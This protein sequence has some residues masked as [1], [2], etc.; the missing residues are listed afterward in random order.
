MNSNISIN[1]EKLT[2]IKC[3]V[4]TQFN[5]CYIKENTI[6]VKVVELHHK[7]KLLISPISGRLCL[8]ICII[9]SKV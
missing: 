2:Y 5:L 6:Y 9:L 3:F 1:F 8:I 7:F 4:N